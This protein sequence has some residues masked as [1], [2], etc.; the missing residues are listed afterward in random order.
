LRILGLVAA[1]GCGAMGASRAEA[2]FSH[3]QP[4]APA[5]ASPAANNV[6]TDFT[7]RC[8]AAS[9]DLDNTQRDA[10]ST[11]AVD[12]PDAADF[13]GGKP[14]SDDHLIKHLTSDKSGG[15]NSYAQ[16]WE[17]NT[18]LSTADP[19]SD[20]GVDVKS[21][22]PVVVPLPDGVWAGLIGLAGV[23]V[24]QIRRHRRQLV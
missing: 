24:F 13:R 15:K 6:G 11:T 10:S 1:M 9:L 3:L 21:T 7:P 19:M 4:P 18:H 5:C 2:A 14:D 8:D 12:L 23:I 16:F 17:D 22:A 20:F